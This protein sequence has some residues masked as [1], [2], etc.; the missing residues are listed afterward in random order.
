MINNVSP[1]YSTFIIMLFHLSHPSSTS[2]HNQPLKVESCPRIHYESALQPFI[3]GYL[4]KILQ[5]LLKIQP[6]FRMS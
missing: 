5:I 6:P 1:L 3:E 4:L 2:K